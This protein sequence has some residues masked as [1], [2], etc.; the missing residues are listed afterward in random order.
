MKNLGCEGE[1]SELL[2]QYRI[3]SPVVVPGI[4][5]A[6]FCF[7]TLF[8]GVA[9]YAKNNEDVLGF[10][11]GLGKWTGDLPND[12]AAGCGLVVFAAIGCA[13]S[14]ALHCAMRPKNSA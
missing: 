9:A 2:K 3:D 11:C 13:V 14:L 6:L 7:T 5:F 10:L 4:V 1:E 12:E 8:M